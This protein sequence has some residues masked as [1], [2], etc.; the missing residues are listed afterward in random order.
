MPQWAHGHA[1]H[2]LS[3][4]VK[5]RRRCVTVMVRGRFSSPRHMTVMVRGRLS[6]PP[7][8]D[9]HGQGALAAPPDTPPCSVYIKRDGAEGARGSLARDRTLL[10]HLPSPLRRL[11]HPPPA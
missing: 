11:G 10:E 5:V 7:T 3:E 1:T 2:E 4:C 8:R 6:S 9:R